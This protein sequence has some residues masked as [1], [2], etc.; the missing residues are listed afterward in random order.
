MRRVFGIFS[1]S[2]AAV[3]CLGLLSAI[4]AI[5]LAV[6][7][8]RAI[9]SLRADQPL[10][11]GWY[12]AVGYE[13]LL[14][15]A[16]ALLTPVLIARSGR[17]LGALQRHQLVRHYLAI[18]PLAVRRLGEGE[19]VDAA[20]DAV[21]RSVR[22]RTSFMGPAICAVATPVL[23]LLGIVFFIDPLSA[24]MLLLPTML[25]PVL[26]IGFQRLF[27]GS[28]GE[29]RRA[30][31]LLSATFLDGLRALT[32]LKLNGGA[33]WM[34]QR[35]AVASE[36]V[37]QQVMKLLARNQLVLL[38]IDASFAVLLLATA[39]LLA[40][41]RVGSLA[42]TPGEGAALVLLSFLMLAPVNYVGSFF[43]IGMT[44]KAAEQKIESFMDTERH[45][46]AANPLRVDLR[47]DALQLLDLG[48][49]YE[50]H[51]AALEQLNFSFPAGSK[52]A[53]IGASG[54]GKTTLLRVL[55]GQL[56]TTAGIIHDGHQALGP[57]TLRSNTAVVEQGTTLFGISLRENLLLAA[58]QASDEKLRAMLRRAGL[59]PWFA[60][61]EA[62][63]DTVL[64]EGG[65]TLSGGQ[66][67]RLAI[68]RALLAERPILLLDEPT[69]SLDV[70]TEAE[71]LDTLRE[72][73]AGLTVITVT[74][75]L[76]LL[77]DYDQVLVLDRGRIVQAGSREELLGTEGYLRTAMENFGQR[78]A[79]LGSQRGNGAK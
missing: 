74:H 78:V 31:G 9:D 51:P 43:Y 62:G 52:T 32:M 77:A 35:I 54:S 58:P 21:D 3:V 29:Y 28:S 20:M 49:G 39:A 19:L 60:Q 79:A 41:W 46:A 17:K 12:V 75:R 71:V 4:G 16:A 66:A 2:T 34:G 5:G 47:A 63:L 13:L 55:Q 7:I 61:Q 36:R 57:A 42:I 40:W 48:A 73:A 76:G 44:G 23:V 14:V 18:G 70:Q 25:V 24:L 72:V 33:S 11:V 26:V 64:G 45:R 53:V 67:Q 6:L 27:R 50:G 22:F 59:A 37:R 65:A 69:S 15:A 10:D 8:G 1:A 56:E 68:A 38:V 30:Q